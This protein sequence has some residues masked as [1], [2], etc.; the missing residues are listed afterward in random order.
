MFVARPQ[1]TL[2]KPEHLFQPRRFL[3]RF[4]GRPDRL[5]P[6]ART[7]FGLD[8]DVMPNEMISNSVRRNGMFDI[9]TAEVLYRLL[10]E[11]EDALD[12]GA[13]VGL[14]S[15]VMALRARRVR[16]LEPHPDVFSRLQR[17]AAR[18]NAVTKRDAMSPLQAAASSAAGEQTLVLPADWRGNTG[19]AT[20]A[21]PEESSDAGIRVACVALDDLVTDSFRPA[22]MKLDVE[23]HELAVLGGASRL[24]QGS[25]RDVVFED[26]GVYPTPV[27]K[28]FE[29]NGFTIFAISRNLLRPRISSP[30]RSGL[31]KRTDPN[32]LA[33]RDPARARDRMHALKWNVLRTMIAGE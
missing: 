9:T 3:S 20:L 8:L 25:L 29:A 16:S 5:S 7:T 33:T 31:S 13:H 26:F 21:G 22:V 28:F 30:D 10:D 27:M 17:N 32:Y 14:M 6:T 4:V 15:A 12:V 19:S 18:F 2:L 11:G 23:G 1:T 24:I